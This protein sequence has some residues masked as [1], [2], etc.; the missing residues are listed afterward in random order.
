MKVSTLTHSGWR[1]VQL[2]GSHLSEPQAD[3]CAT[4][5]TSIIKF[6]I[7]TNITTWCYNGFY[8][9]SHYHATR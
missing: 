3:F 7:F 5:F 4:N 1:V 9:T 2:R 8:E 6:I